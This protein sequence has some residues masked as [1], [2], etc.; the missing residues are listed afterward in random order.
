MEGFVGGIIQIDHSSTAQKVQLIGR[1]TVV[2]HV[3]ELSRIASVRDVQEYVKLARASYE[4]THADKQ[5]ALKVKLLQNEY[6]NLSFH[7]ADDTLRQRIADM[8]LKEGWSNLGFLSY[9]DSCNHV[10]MMDTWGWNPGPCT[11]SGE[12]C[13]K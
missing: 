6:V 1:E 7:T 8:L 5:K 10:H 13:T 2:E 12:R 9:E 4:C 11:T 3:A